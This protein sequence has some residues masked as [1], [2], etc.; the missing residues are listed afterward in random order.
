MGGVVCP[1]WGGGTLAALG[2]AR[3]RTVIFSLC[4]LKVISNKIYFQRL[5]CNNSTEHF[6]R[7]GILG[8]SRIK[9]VGTFPFYFVLT[10][11]I[12]LYNYIALFYYLGCILII[13][14][15]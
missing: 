2:R 1:V 8:N 3:R 13:N 5:H 7:D 4:F 9:S 12:I 10:T 11:I 15:S 6:N 14:N